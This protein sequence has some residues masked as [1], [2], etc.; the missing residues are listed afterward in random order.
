VNKVAN[1]PA[2]RRSIN[3]QIAQQLVSSLFDTRITSAIDYHVLAYMSPYADTSG[4]IVPDAS[5]RLASDPNVIAEDLGISKPSVFRAF[6][7]LET[8]GYI[9]WDRA[10][11][12]ERAL[13]LTGRVR[14][15]LPE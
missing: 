15:V 9:Q 3:M 7:R 12:N 8:N 10:V 4:N 11:G 13:G 5:G 14:I 1:K 2:S 6:G